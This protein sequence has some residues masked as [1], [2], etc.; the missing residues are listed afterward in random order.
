MQPV[1]EALLRD[2]RCGSLVK[3]TVEGCGINS[4]GKYCSEIVNNDAFS[5]LS[6]ASDT[7]SAAKHVLVTLATNC[8]SVGTT[9]CSSS[10][11]QSIQKAN[12]DYGCCLDIYNQSV[13]A[14]GVNCP[15]LSYEVW[16]SCGVDPQGTCES[17]LSIARREDEFEWLTS[18]LSNSS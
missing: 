13:R 10:C 5:A 18:L 1:V 12:L 9:S 14:V 8:N 4:N 7:N 2:G 15:S 6:S 11:Q 16:R 17:T 3:T